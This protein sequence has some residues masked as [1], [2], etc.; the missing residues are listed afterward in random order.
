MESP[1]AD[2][3]KTPVAPY[4]KKAQTVRKKHHG[5]FCGKAFLIFP[6]NGLR[7]REYI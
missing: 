7:T 1:L 4:L 3:Q 6:K 2:F 5:I